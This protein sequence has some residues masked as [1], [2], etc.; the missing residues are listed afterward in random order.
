MWKLLN[1]II[2]CEME[3]YIFILMCNNIFC[4]KLKGVIVWSKW[5]CAVEDVERFNFLQWPPYMNIIYV[6]HQVCPNPSTLFLALHVVK[7][8][9][10]KRKLNIWWKFSLVHI[11][12]VVYII[13]VYVM[14]KTMGPYCLRNHVIMCLTFNYKCN[15]K[16]NVMANHINK[17]VH[18]AS[19]NGIRNGWKHFTKW[20]GVKPKWFRFVRYKR[21]VIF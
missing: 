5:W 17:I 6:C 16:C 2:L 13:V 4:H 8:F 3:I 19:M 14:V 11:I 7:T 18:L 21:W 15:H 1:F 20:H 12:I 9:A 10:F